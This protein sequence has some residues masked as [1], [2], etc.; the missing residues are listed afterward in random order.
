MSP[1]RWP[2][3]RPKHVG[4]KYNN[5]IDLVDLSAFCWFLIKIIQ[6]HG[7]SVANIKIVSTVCAL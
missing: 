1:R 6:I 2:H 7:M 3:Y 4:E 5:T